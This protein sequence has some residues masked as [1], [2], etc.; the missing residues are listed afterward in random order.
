MSE[1]KNVETSPVKHI[2]MCNGSTITFT[3]SDKA[4]KLISI[5]GFVHCP[6]CGTPW[7]NEYDAATCS[8]LDV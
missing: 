1:T 6:N 3:Q 7:E 4:D 8:C 5:D 2:V